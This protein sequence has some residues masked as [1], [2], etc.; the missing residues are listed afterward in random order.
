MFSTVIFSY[1][2]LAEKS[3]CYTENSNTRSNSS[4]KLCGIMSMVNYMYPQWHPV[5]CDVPTRAYVVC[6]HPYLYHTKYRP[7]PTSLRQDKPL[8]AQ[9]YCGT[10]EML[11]ENECFIFTRNFSKNVHV[12][13]NNEFRKHIKM[14]GGRTVDK[15][16]NISVVMEYLSH[17]SYLKPVFIFPR[18]YEANQFY[19]YCTRR[20][21]VKSKRLFYITHTIRKNLPSKYDIYGCIS[22]MPN[23]LMVQKQLMIA[24]KNAEADDMFYCF[25]N[26]KIHSF[27]TK[28]IYKLLKKKPF[29]FGY[30]DS[31]TQFYQYDV[32]LN[33]FVKY[34]NTTDA[35]NT[36]YVIKS[37]LPDKIDHLKSNYSTHLC[38]SKEYVSLIVVLDGAYDCKSR[39]DEISPIPCNHDGQIKNSSFCETYC[40][41]PKCTCPDLYYQKAKGGCS[42]Y[43]INVKDLSNDAKIKF[44][45]YGTKFHK[46]NINHV[47]TDSIVIEEQEIE[48]IN[49]SYDPET[50]IQLDCTQ[51]ELQYLGEL[52][53][54]YLVKTC[55][56]FN[57][58][59]CTYGCAKCFPIHKLCV[60]DLDQN[61]V[62]RYCPS[63]AHLKNCD[64]IGCNTM[65]K[66]K[67]NYCLPFK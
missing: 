16:L 51:K 65:F 26:G 13:T 17:V 67:N 56:S 52:H 66:C 19:S 14:C 50:N 63:G 6:S 4:S 41:R 30:S 5:P 49:I 10:G 45:D 28:D 37:K 24:R 2:C 42:P 64:R 55:S 12:L 15:Y 8:V 57:E 62:L 36:F 21:S 9:K 48:R 3:R 25:I 40:R 39:D 35:N 29:Y 33:K 59:Q 38:I 27:Q 43:N 32:M 34:Q 61:G 7:R 44:L 18:G 58:L 31:I 46:T 22:D 23:H 11:F 54:T 60:Y 1:H 20:E 53:S 47:Y